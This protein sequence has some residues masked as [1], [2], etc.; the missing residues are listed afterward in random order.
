MNGIINP[1]IHRRPNP[2]IRTADSHD[3]CDFPPVVVHKFVT[4]HTRDR[5]VRR[6]KGNVRHIITNPKPVEL[7]LLIEVVHGE[8]RLFV[9]D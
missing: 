2:T 5:I 4:P 8:E 3:L 1:L 9:W 6:E 7:S